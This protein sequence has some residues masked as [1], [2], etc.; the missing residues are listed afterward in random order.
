MEELRTYGVDTKVQFGKV[1]YVR[2]A[3]TRL[4]IDKYGRV[5]LF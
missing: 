3:N 2:V 1:S 4:G 5:G